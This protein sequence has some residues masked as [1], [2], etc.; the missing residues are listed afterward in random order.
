MKKIIILK[1]L[2]GSGKST[3]AKEFVRT[4]ADWKRINKDDLRA[5]M[6]DSKWS[7][8][9]EQYILATRDLLINRFLLDGYNVI[10]DDTN[11]N[12]KH[13]EHI[14]EMAKTITESGTPCEVEV[15]FFD[16]PIGECIKR[17]LN[18]P[19]SV[20]EAVIRKMYN[21][22]LK[23]KA[24]LYLPD[25]NLPRAVIF[26]IDGTLAHMNG[27]SPFE[28]DKVDEDVADTK[29]VDLLR[30]FKNDQYHEYNIFIF[31]GRDEV[32]R[33]KTESWLY[34]HGI[35]YEELLMRPAGNTE[36]DAVIKKRMFELLSKQFRIE[37]IFDDRNQCVDLWRSLGLKC[38][39]VAD[40]D[41]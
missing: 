38:L 9:R 26:D 28:W 41:F 4:N 14:K 36:K 32:C 25:Q 33:E 37:F 22:Y 11:L 27:R 31:T 19:K 15:K 6:D 17:D 2:P 13:E 21:D 24:E 18:R 34:K 29:M 23:P 3:W 5:M 40:G 10:V 20:G 1:G 39:Q 35:I 30:L 7:G 12:P 8:K 16:T